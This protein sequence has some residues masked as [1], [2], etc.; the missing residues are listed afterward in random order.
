MRLLIEFVFWM[1]VGGCATFGGL[2]LAAQLL[3]LV[4][5]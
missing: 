4:L 1:M 2:I 5:Q 3:I